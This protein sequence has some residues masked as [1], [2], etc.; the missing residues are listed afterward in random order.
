[1]CDLVKAIKEISIHQGQR[2]FCIGGADFN[3]QWGECRDLTG[4][5]SKGERVGETERAREIYGFLASQGMRIAN[6]FVDLGFTRF[7]PDSLDQR[8]SQIDGICVSHSLAFR[9]LGRCTLPY[10]PPSDHVPLCFEIIARK[11]NKRDRA[12]LFKRKGCRTAGVESS[13]HVLG[14]SGHA[15]FS[16]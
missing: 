9:S 10:Q 16:A 7:P 14:T 1:M 12:A 11:V 4:R 2:T 3:C 8:P 13:P 5:F 6:S 15:E